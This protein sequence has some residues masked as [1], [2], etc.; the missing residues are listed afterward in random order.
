MNILL[1][2]AAGLSTSLLVNKM[3]A[4]LTEEQ[5]GWRIEAHPIAETADFINDFDVVLL[6]PQVGHK[7]NAVK[8]DFDSYNKPIAVINPVDYGMGRGKEVVEFAAKL[9]REQ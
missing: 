8:K 7:L 3:K 5:K 1:V 2:C 9:Y 6:G 4:S